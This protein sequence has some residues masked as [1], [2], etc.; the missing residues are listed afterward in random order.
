[1]AETSTSIGA[2]I[3]HAFN[4]LAWLLQFKTHGG[5]YVVT[6]SRV[7]LF[8]AKTGNPAEQQRKAQIMLS[9][10]TV[11]QRD[12]IEAHL[13]DRPQPAPRV[14][15]RERREVPVV[16]FGFIGKITRACREHH[17]AMATFGR[18]AVRDS[19]FVFE[20][21]AGRAVRPATEAK[22]LAFIAGLNGGDR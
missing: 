1:M 11:Q 15:R 22:V 14:E 3:A 18:R 17:M 2:P 12:R 8:V 10:L 5:G 20:L 19:G 7:H 6:N 4:P 16:S 13:I 21:L 9:A